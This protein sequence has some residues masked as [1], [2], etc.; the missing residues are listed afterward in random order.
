VLET[1]AVVLAG[2][3]GTRL[4]PLT[5]GTPKPVLP[6]GGPY[7][8][9]DFVFSNCVDSGVPTVLFVTQQCDDPVARYVERLRD[10]ISR[11]RSCTLLVS[12]AT[13]GNVGNATAEAV[14]DALPVVRRGGHRRVLILA[15][16]HVYRMSYASMIDY[17][18]A[19]GA[20]VTV[21]TV[22]VPLGEAY[23]YGVLEAEA[24]GRIRS[25]VEKPSCP[26]AA[27]GRPG[28]A[29]ASMGI[30]VFDR[31]L[32]EETLATDSLDASSTHDFGRDII[33]RLVR[34][35]HA[36]AYPFDGYWRDVGTIDAYVAAHRDFLGSPTGLPLCDPRWPLRTAAWRI[37][38]G[39][40]SVSRHGSLLSPGCLCEPGS[41]VRGSTVSP[42]ARIGAGAALEDCI[43]LDGAQVG[44]G[45]QLRR[46]IVDIGE[47]VLEGARMGWECGDEQPVT[48]VSGGQIWT[49]TQAR[50]D[51][52]PVLA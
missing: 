10:T 22:E 31:D 27:W 11:A 7:R 17:H 19:V 18:G 47:T 33:P 48:V 39:S 52:E 40:L 20:G 43:V 5:R 46:V 29:R 44:R 37:L 8:L 25:F 15:S 6:F 23:R 30:Y 38:P 28:R 51:P 34:S 21:G 35:G 3:Q 12:G 2:G 50:R 4:S 16:D 13:S 1:L 14:L 41:R 26:P 42:A 45:A 9:A 49:I 36:W 24:S 32:L